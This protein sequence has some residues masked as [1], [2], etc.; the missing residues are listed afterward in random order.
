MIYII[1]IIQLDHHLKAKN[2]NNQKMKNIV[3]MYY[4]KSMKTHQTEKDSKIF[5]T[6]IFYILSILSIAST[7]TKLYKHI[8]EGNIKSHKKYI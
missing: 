8:S 7:K 6:Q 5:N 1:Y 2:F 3:A 4:R